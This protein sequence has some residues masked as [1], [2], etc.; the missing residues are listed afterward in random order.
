MK[1]RSPIISILG[2]V[3]HGK[4][5]ILDRIRKDNIAE[6][7]AGGITQA[8]GAYEIEHQGRKIT[9]I[10]TP[11][12]EAFSKMRARGAKVADLAILVVAAD[13]GVMPQTKDAIKHI[14]KAGIPYVVAINKI[15]LP[16]ADIEKTKQDLV[17]AEVFLEGMGG[18][19]SYQTI[20][21]LKGEGIDELLDLVNLVADVEGL[22]YNPNVSGEGIILTSVR[23][24]NRGITVGLIIKNGEIKKGDK[25][26]SE[27]T[28]GK[29]KVL[30]NFLGEQVEKLIPSSPALILGFENLPEVGEI[31]KVGERPEISKATGPQIKE[32][33][34][35]GDKK[36]K[37]V[38]KADESGSLEAVNDMISRLS[39]EP[40]IIISKG[41]GNVNESDLKTAASFNAVVIGFNANVDKVA[42]NF[43]KIQKIDIITSDVIYELEEKLREYIEEHAVKEKRTI[44][45]LAI[46]NAKEGNQQVV[47]GKVIG[48]YIENQEKFEIF[49]DDNKIGEG[50]IINLQ[51]GKEDIAR[52]EENQEVGLLVKSDVNILE[53]HHLVFTRK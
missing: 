2:H 36:V 8:I 29:V 5:T 27:S 44:E 39:K 46:F 23:N 4:T 6:K 9:F 35:E 24:S 42:E 43:A 15:D 22:T 37:V 28:E 31:F 18:D 11:G 7:E 26:F 3:D 25:L 49:R 47:G 53:G 30:E 40:P 12:H 33:I 10:D 45:I 14:K 19:I 51:S 50:R 21:A 48:E 52:A 32:A 1:K 17:Q 34:P 20:S 13:D 38:V 16:G 41:V